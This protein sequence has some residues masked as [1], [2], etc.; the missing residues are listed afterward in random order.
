M[1]ICI[2]VLNEHLDSARESAKKIPQFE[3]HTA[4][5]I[6]VSENADL[7]ASHW[8][9]SFNASDDV[10]EQIKNL[11]EFSEVVESDPK[12]FLQSKNLQIIPLRKVIAARKAQRQSE[13]NK[14]ESNE[15]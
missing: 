6:P 10:F 8:F 14:N 11:Q 13:K 15:S 3:K 1:V 4:L 5:A 12:E 2:L 9:C 7:P